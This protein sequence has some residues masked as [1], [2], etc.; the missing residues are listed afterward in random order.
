MDA[1]RAR[2]W[3]ARA[4]LGLAVLSAVV[5]LAFAG[6]RSVGLV[7]LTAAAVVVILAG[8]F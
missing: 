7:L 5:L 8:G 3:W 4:A 2:G 1:M 6:R